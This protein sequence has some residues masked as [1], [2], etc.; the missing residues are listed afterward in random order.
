MKYNFKEIGN[1]IRAFRQSKG[2]SQNEFIAQLNQKCY[3]S[4]SR[5]TISKI[6]GGNRDNFTLELL[7]SVCEL[8]NCD[9]GYILGE[10]GDCNTRDAQ[11][12]YES[13]GINGENVG[14]LQ[15]FNISKATKSKEASRVY[16]IPSQD[17]ADINSLIGEVGLAWTNDMIDAFIASNDI[18]IGY[19][20]VC[21]R[22]P[23]YNTDQQNRLYHTVKAMTTEI[24]GYEIVALEEYIRFK[25][26]D[27][28]KAT[29]RYLIDKYLKGE[30]G[31]GN[32][33]EA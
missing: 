14:R 19:M 27:V 3:L 32:D 22:S 1:R 31:N 24:P 30:D 28:M 5:N 16:G 2:W 12:I 25:I 26:S 4:I 13:T 10:Y 33:R 6:E 18:L 23:L 9:M 17:G 29:E 11:F 15:A 21:K 7:L 20:D 8:F